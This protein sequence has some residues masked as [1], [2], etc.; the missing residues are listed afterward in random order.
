MSVSMHIQKE[1]LKE[2]EAGGVDLRRV[3]ISCPAA[4]HR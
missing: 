3:E 2:R 1:I 4:Q